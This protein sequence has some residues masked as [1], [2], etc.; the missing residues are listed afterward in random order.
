[1]QCLTVDVNRNL[2]S[3]LYEERHSVVSFFLIS[4]AIKTAKTTK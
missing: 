1:M 3:E 2:M 4:L